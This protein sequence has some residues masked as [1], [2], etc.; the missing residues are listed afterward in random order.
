MGLIITS[1]NRKIISS[2]RVIAFGEN[3]DITFSF[4]GEEV[5]YFDFTFRLKFI[6]DEKESQKI[7]RNIDGSTVEVECWNFSDAGTGTGRPVKLA[8]VQDKYI[9][10]SFWAYLEGDFSG[11][12]KTRKVDYTFFIG[13]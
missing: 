9:Y 11:K 10:V 5:L 12:K 1:E 6:N 3:A 7:I 13:E 8:Q 4:S 2:G